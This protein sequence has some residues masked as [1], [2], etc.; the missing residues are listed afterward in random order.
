MTLAI[1]NHWAEIFIAGAIIV[2]ALV[3]AFRSPTQTFASPGLATSIGTA[4]T[5]TAYT[6][7][8]STRVL[9]STTNPL[10]GN[11]SFVRVYATICNPSATVV[12]LNL[13]GD[14]QAS[15]PGSS[16]TAVIAAAAG[17]NAC[18]EINDRNEYSGSVQASSTNQT[19]TSVYVTDYVVR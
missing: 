16:T 19:A 4:T 15:A 7:T 1:K 17:Y 8:S 10:D 6:V 13:N 18:Y 3:L 2:L 12:Y 9:A 11:N 5:S 14:K